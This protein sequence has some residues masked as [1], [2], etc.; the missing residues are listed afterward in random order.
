MIQ[1]LDAHARH[2]APS[3][4]VWGSCYQKWQKVDTNHCGKWGLLSILAR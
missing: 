4:A 1:S 3:S 2:E